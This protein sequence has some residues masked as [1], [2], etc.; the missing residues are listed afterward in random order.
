MQN[1][2]LCGFAC[3]FSENTEV[4]PI[5]PDRKSYSLSLTLARL[6]TDTEISQA[7]RFLSKSQIVYEKARFF[8]R[9]KKK[10]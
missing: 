5:F 1:G 10:F 6:A 2:L 3:I 7:E 4:Y 9:I 8:K